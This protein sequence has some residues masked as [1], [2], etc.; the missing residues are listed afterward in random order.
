MDPELFAD[1]RPAFGDVQATKSGHLHG[2][3]FSPV[4]IVLACIILFSFAIPNNLD[5]PLVLTL[6]W[7]SSW[8][9]CVGASSIAILYI[10]V[11]GMD[12]VNDS[13][14]DGPNWALQS[15]RLIPCIW[16]VFAAVFLVISVIFRP[17]LVVFQPTE[18]Q[19]FPIRITAGC[20]GAISMMW[21]LLARLRHVSQEK[22]YTKP[23]KG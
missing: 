1:P 4:L 7:L 13:T 11:R 22:A 18:S 3:N 23:P 10:R 9:V 5:D 17:L 8:C 19:M 6:T 16:T 12:V 21:A 2:L 15:I 20:M 14:F